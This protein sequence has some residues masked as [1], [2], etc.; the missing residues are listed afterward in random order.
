APSAGT[1]G[2]RLRPAQNAR[3]SSSG[4]PLASQ[5]QGLC[6]HQSRRLPAGFNRTRIKQTGLLA[7]AM[8]ACLRL[9]SEQ[10]QVWTGHEPLDA[11]ANTVRLATM[12]TT[13]LDN[14]TSH[15]FRS[16][17]R[18][19]ARGEQALFGICAGPIAKA[20]KEGVAFR[21]LLHPIEADG[22]VFK[23]PGSQ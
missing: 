5:A 4:R 7:P 6:I 23:S 15:V 12:F 13:L 2:L 3:H 22:L 10:F 11:I 9:A 20:C 16:T 14:K 17:S 8:P 19:A 21:V 18:I 1:S